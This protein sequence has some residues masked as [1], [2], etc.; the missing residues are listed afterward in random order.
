ML[1]YGFDPFDTFDLFDLHDRFDYQLRCLR[2]NTYV[3]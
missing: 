2:F 3:I 1:V